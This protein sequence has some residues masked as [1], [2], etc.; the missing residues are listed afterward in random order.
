MG[1]DYR[2]LKI[3]PISQ[4]NEAVK[5]VKKYPDTY[6]KGELAYSLTTPDFREITAYNANK[7]YKDILGN[8]EILPFYSNFVLVDKKT[9]KIHEE[10]FYSIKQIVL[11]LNSRRN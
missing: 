7:K 4:A 10:I 6:Y 8:W 3:I 9:R 1:K 11:K 2:V 5:E